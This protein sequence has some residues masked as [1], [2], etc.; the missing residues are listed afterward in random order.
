MIGS[1]SHL[2]VGGVLAAALNLLAV[3]GASAVTGTQQATPAGS[4]SVQP[5]AKGSTSGDLSLHSSASSGVVMVNP[6]VY[7]VFWGSQ[8]SNDPAGAEA[9]LQ[10]LFASLNGS[11]DTW[12]T[13]LTQYCEGLPVGT[14]SCGTA[15]TH[16][17]HPTSSILGGVFLDTGSAAP[18]KATNT[19]LAQEAIRAAGHFGNTNQAANYNDQYVIA[20]PSGTHPGG[21]P[22]GFC[23]WH[24]ST[25]S[26]YGNLAFT[27]LP[28]VPD[29]G[30]GACTTI[31]GARL[32][33]GYE[34]SE[35]HEYAETVTDPFPSTGWLKGGAEI[36]DLCENLDAYLT[37]GSNTFD[38]Q[39]LWSNSAA[40][41]ATNQVAATA[42]A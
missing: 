42:K 10:N 6:K 36:G 4:K 32:I 15:G 20:S 37:I 11:S 3:P 19:Q 35:T 31:P 21:F 16:I 2:M 25:S 1:R 28:Y 27:N 33:D 14:V 9:A 23:A 40:A 29:L 8:W 5:S 41:C 34:S 12:G 26:A 17:T 13:I 7:L 22:K 38:V 24:N 39:G 18:S 30:A